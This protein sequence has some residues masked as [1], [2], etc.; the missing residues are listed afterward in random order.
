[1]SLDRRRSWLFYGSDRGGQRA[2]VIYS[3]IVT[4]KV[5]DVDP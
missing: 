3:L 1:M 5:N 2:A 4:A